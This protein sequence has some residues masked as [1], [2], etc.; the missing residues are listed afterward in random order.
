VPAPRRGAGLIDKVVYPAGAAAL[1]LLGGCVQALFFH[2][3][4][5]EYR[6]PEKLGLTV[7]DVTFRAE[8]RSPLDGW[9]FPADPKAGP[10]QCTVVHAHGNAANI[11]R[12]LEA[13]AWLP[14]LGIN[15]LMFDYRGFGVSL[16]K[17]S[18]DG[19]VAD[20]EAAVHAALKMPGA[21]PGRLVLFGQ[22]LGGATAIRAA[23]ELGPGLVQ[24]LVVDSAFARYRDVAHHVA[25]DIKVLKLV[26]GIV[27]N[28]LPGDEDDPVIAIARL[29]VPVWIIHGDADRV[30]PFQQG[31]RLFEAAR[32]PKTWVP[33]A[34]GEH[35]HA[36]QRPEVRQMVL[37]ALREVCGP[38]T[39]AESSSR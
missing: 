28:T 14:A 5:R 22:S 21:T 34:G 24:G 23:D 1:L 15:V 18:L 37:A 33:V 19:V 13:V 3:D 4:N 27:R 11:S 32:E 26:S 6:E 16:G 17:P 25:E 20:T 36:M 2:P 12:H 38:A 9:W 30:V 35:L 39:A 29:Q 31:Q 8:D 10:P 7:V